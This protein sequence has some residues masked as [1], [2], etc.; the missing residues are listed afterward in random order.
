MYSRN[1]HQ[2]L[3][4]MLFLREAIVKKGRWKQHSFVVYNFTIVDH[5]GAWR[6]L[7]AAG[8]AK[9]HPLVASFYI[10]Y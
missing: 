9:N 10:M 5:L 2:S 3:A 8:P 7:S 6:H 1:A 4:F